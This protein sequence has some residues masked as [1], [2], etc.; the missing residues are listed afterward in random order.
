[1]TVDAPPQPS[2]ETALF[3]LLHPAQIAVVEAHV[4]IGEPMSSKRLHEVLGGTWPLG[5]IAYHVRRLAQKGVLEERY[6]EPVRGVVEYFY[7][8]AR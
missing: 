8:L 7:G 1:M 6:R 2:W 4:W 5:T 3:S